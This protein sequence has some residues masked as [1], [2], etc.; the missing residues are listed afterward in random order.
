MIFSLSS[1]LQNHLQEIEQSIYLGLGK[2]D[3]LY[4]VGVLY[5]YFTSS[6]ENYKQFDKG[7]DPLFEKEPI[8]NLE[9]RKIKFY[10]IGIMSSN[11]Y[12]L[13]ENLENRTEQQQDLLTILEENNLPD[14][15]TYFYQDIHFA[16]NL[17][18]MYLSSNDY[19]QEEREDL[20]K[21]LPNHKEK[22]LFE[23]N[24]LLIGEDIEKKY[25]KQKH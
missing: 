18:K 23:L 9:S 15:I 20:R 11:C 16:T 13:L 19:I 10:Q 1:I 22:H 3:Q 17:I 8:D 5:H 7:L 14:I 24:P 6:H 4:Q 25:Q 21:D 12:L 2:E